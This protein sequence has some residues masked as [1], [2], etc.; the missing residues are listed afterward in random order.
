[1]L[2]LFGVDLYVR[3]VESGVPCN[4]VHKLHKIMSVQRDTVAEWLR[5]STRNRLGL[6]RV[7]SSPASVDFFFAG[8]GTM[9]C[10]AEHDGFVTSQHKVCYSVLFLGISVRV[11]ATW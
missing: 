11:L 5:R 8:G 7:G 2:L 3:V 9:Q 1:M 4:R 6:S 10:A